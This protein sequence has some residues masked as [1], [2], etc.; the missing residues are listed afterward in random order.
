MPVKT[1]APLSSLASE[2]SEHPACVPSAAAVKAMP[3]KSDSRL[4]WCRVRTGP[5]RGFGF[6]VVREAIGTFRY[7][8]VGAFAA[9]I[10]A[11]TALANAALG[12]Y[13][14]LGKHHSG[15]P[16]AYWDILPPL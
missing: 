3:T 6:G 9:E 13:A 10:T 16:T 5:W 4:E 8:S 1:R 15:T 7:Q 2:R 12:K 14:C 11:F